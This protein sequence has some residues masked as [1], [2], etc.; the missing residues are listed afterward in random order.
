MVGLL[1]KLT[2]I[3]N[4]PMWGCLLGASQPGIGRTIVIIA[5]MHRRDLCARLAPI[6]EY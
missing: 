1:G 4:I 3:D 2:E 5:D 6:H